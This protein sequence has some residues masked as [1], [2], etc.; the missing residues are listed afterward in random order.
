MKKIQTKLYG[1][2]VELIFQPY[3]HKYTV[4]GGKRVTSVTQ[5]LSIIN[6]PALINWAARMAVEFIADQ[7]EAGQ[8]YD[9]VQLLTIFDEAK[10]AHYKKKV[11][12]GNVGTFVHNWVED[13]INGKNP[14]TPV[15]PGIKA[16][17]ERFLAWQKEHKV[18]FLV[19]EQ[20]VYSKKY[21]YTGTLDFICEIDGKMYIGDL[22][23][24]SGIYPE[25]M[26]QTAAYRYA[27]EEEYPEEKYA[28]QVIVK[29]G[30]EDGSLEVAAIK[31]GEWYPKMLMAFIAALKLKESME[32]IKQ[33]RHEKI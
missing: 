22:K 26:I 11:S 27:R 8:A 16:A 15:N 17:I 6:K 33:F 3:G 21:N 9:E 20:Q 18:K 19:A 14:A 30:K 7:L 25:M 28:G 31:D 10:S 12:A 5:A 32:L 4:D 13:Y 29:V 1:G 23:T 24:S 2:N